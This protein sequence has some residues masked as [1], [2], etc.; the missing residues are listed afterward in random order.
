MFIPNAFTPNG[1]G[2]NEVF[3]P[4][5]HCRAKDYAFKV[6]NRYGGVVFHSADTGKGWDGKAGQMDAPSG[7]YIWWLRYQN[8]ATKELVTKQGT[9]VLLR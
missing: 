8:P 6:F 7:V 5:V 2:R 1:D 3:R 4:I 9:V